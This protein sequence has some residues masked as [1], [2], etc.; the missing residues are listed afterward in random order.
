MAELLKKASDQPR[1]RHLTA[2]LLKQLLAAAPL[3][4]LF[5]D[6]SLIIEYANPSAAKLMGHPAP[7][8]LTGVSL[9][10]IASPA[11]TGIDKQVRQC[12]ESGKTGRVRHSLP[13][14]HGDGQSLR[15]TT[16]PVTNSRGQTVGAAICIEDLSE[17][18]RIES[19]IRQAQ[20]LESMGLLAGGIA[21]D[22]SNI[23]W[24]IMGNVELA[25]AEIEV[26]HPARYNLEVAETAC[27]RA[28][29][30][31]MRII[32]FGRRSKHKRKPIHLNDIVVE[33]LRKLQQEEL[34]KN[35]RVE[36]HRSTEQDMVFV[37]PSE[38]KQMMAHL[39]RNAVQA[40]A[41]RGGVLEVSL[42][43]VALEA[44][45]LTGHPGMIPGRYAILTVMDSGP[46]IQADHLEHVFEPFFSTKPSEQHTG[47]GLAIVKS[48]A[49][50]HGGTVTLD[51]R[52]GKGTLVQVI[53]PTLHESSRLTTKPEPPLP[54]GIGKVLLV[55]S[56]PAVLEMRARMII[57]LG[58]DVEYA[59]N[60]QQALD[61]FLRAPETFDLV[62]T[63]QSMPDIPVT[64]MV[65]KMKNARQQIPIMLCT[66]LGAPALAA[67]ARAAGIDRLLLKP[68]RIKDLAVALK[69]TL[70][71][72]PQR[73]TGR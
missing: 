1:T 7:E 36:H 22:F 40:M 33:S 64:T 9:N 61:L 49:R 37:E 52:P 45:E 18:R 66:V 23:L 15:I 11:L 56:D 57:R 46:G 65:Q 71:V 6:D 59:E 48:I 19:Q 43:D 12:F 42:V 5:V 54:T 4:V 62:I 26:G 73:K 34:P 21:D 50:A 27:R 38:L 69:E 67:N 32:R 13:G 2:A 30:L 72:L 25:E 44:E 47:L 55:D 16:H 17:I 58:Y 60:G 10:H 53:L 35:I 51:S 70:P 63:D 41:A 39:Y 29:E 28:Q 14:V 3:G 68:V 31:V 20:R 24:E 8:S